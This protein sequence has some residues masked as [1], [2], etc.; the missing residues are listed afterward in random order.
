MNNIPQI[1]Q[2]F[3]QNPIGML[4]QRFNIPQNLNNPND[5]IQHLLNTGQ[6]SQ[7]RINQIMGMRNNPMIQQFFNMK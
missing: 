4:S 3:M 5:I 1:Y 6:V 7:Q 2:Q